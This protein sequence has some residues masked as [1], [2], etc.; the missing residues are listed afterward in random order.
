MAGR[1][2]SEAA[3]KRQY[4]RNYRARKKPPPP[5]RVEVEDR[6]AH[7]FDWA[8][9]I[10]TPPGQP[11]AGQP[12]VLGGWQRDFVRRAL[13]DGVTAAYLSVARRNGKSTTIA[14]LILWSLVSEA[15]LPGYSIGV[16]SLT[17][18]LAR[19][20]MGMIEELASANDIELQV[21]RQPP[22]LTGFDGTTA[23]FL[24]STPRNPA[25]TGRGF[26][27]AICDELGQFEESAR[28]ILNNMLGATVG[29]A[30]RMIAISNRGSS[31]FMQEAF[32]RRNDDDVVWVEYAAPAG[33]R[34]DDV[35]AIRAANP[36]IAQGIVSEAS[37]LRHAAAALV[38]ESQQNDF[39]RY[40]LNQRVDGHAELLVGLEG[41]FNAVVTELPP[42]KGECVLGIDIG[43]SSSMTA[44]AAYWAATGRLEIY[45][46]FPDTPDLVTRGLTDGVG[47]TYQRM[48]DRGELRLYPGKHTD[49][50]R[51]VWDLAAELEPD[52]V[53]ADRYRRAEVET[54]LDAGG[55]DWAME[56]RALGSGRHGHADVR[57]TRKAFL[58]GRVKTLE[59]LVL[60]SAIRRSTVR[61]DSNGN[62][63]LIRYRSTSRIDAA[64]ALVLAIGGGRE[65]E[66]GEWQIAVV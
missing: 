49:A 39:R 18:D 48:F 50:K 34:L 23:V 1:R 59:N 29:R 12:M 32:D 16:V 4:M 33:A 11:R 55:I 26:D 58:A 53:I 37:L 17:G 9:Q 20:L 45:A 8:S 22:V 54:A 56:W 21:R 27:L 63:S 60:E 5:P 61:F 24:N 31:P 3:Y 66:V 46:A 65:E 43:G 62:P 52:I 30:G 10:I 44:A 41:Y 57:A 35:A 64:Q 6:P 40:H 47:D 7:F 15:R 25:G 51:F 42:R 14:L 28:P 36:G 2:V 13:A 38:T 19:V